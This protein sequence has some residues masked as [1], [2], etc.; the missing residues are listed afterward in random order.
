L[1]RDFLRLVLLANL[2]AWPLAWY[3]SRRWLENFAY[4]IA[5][6]PWFFGAAGGAALV[7]ALVTV[8]FQALRA[9]RV[10]PATT[11]KTD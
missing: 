8:G 3:A 11:L 10:N 1:S 7:I 4:R 5:I 2:V 6:S 9:T